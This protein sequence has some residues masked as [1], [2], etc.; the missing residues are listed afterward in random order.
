MRPPNGEAWHRLLTALDMALNCYLGAKGRKDADKPLVADM[1]VALGKSG[2]GGNSIAV[3]QFPLGAFIASPLQRLAQICVRTA[4]VKQHVKRTDPAALVAYTAAVHGVPALV[5]ALGLKRAP[6]LANLVISNPFGMPERRYPAGAE[7][8][9][10]L[11]LSLLTHGRSLNISAVTYDKGLQV[12]FL[13]L[14]SDI[15]DVQLI[16]D[17]TVEAFSELLASAPKPPA[18]ARSAVGK[19]TKTAE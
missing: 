19:A 9:S 11:G 7:V 6:M 10:A 3:L 15:P 5:E 13:A 8:E 1:P 18:R 12:L 14:A 17:Y 16:A 2:E 4:E